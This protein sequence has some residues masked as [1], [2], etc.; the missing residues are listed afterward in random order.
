MPS[1]M[2][3]APIP[4]SGNTTNGSAPYTS[5]YG[6]YA[7]HLSNTSDPRLVQPTF[8]AAV[9]QKSPLP[10]MTSSW[11]QDRDSMASETDAAGAAAA[12]GTAAQNKKGS[13]AGMIEL[14]GSVPG[15]AR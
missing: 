4:A 11:F 15:Q 2:T 13:M 5:V 9:N 14:M 10:Q 3:G 12:H 6:G 7:G 1:R 8:A